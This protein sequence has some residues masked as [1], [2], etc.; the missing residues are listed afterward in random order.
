MCNRSGQEFKPVKLQ[1]VSC[2]DIIKS[3]YPG[4]WTSCSCFRMS[5]GS[6]GIF[7]DQSRTYM[8]QGGSSDSRLI[9]DIVTEA[10]YYCANLKW[11]IL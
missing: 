10:E 11:D 8:R 1:C 5:K 2:K 6:T 3:E 4:D 9:E 7:V